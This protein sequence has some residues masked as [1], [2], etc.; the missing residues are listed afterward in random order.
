MLSIL[1]AIFYIP[2]YN[3][4]VAILHI[5][6]IDAGIAVI[7]L[8]C[9]VKLVLFPLSKKALRSQIQMKEIDTDLKKIK[10]KYKDDQQL[11][12]KKTMEL[13]KEKGINPFSSILVLLI[14][15]P[16]IISL[17]SIFRSG[18]V[19]I[20]DP[21]LLYSFVHIPAHVS[22]M[23]LGL[24][25]VLAKNPFLAGLTAITQFLQAYLQPIPVQVR[26]EGEKTTFQ[27]D[28]SRSMGVQVRYVFPIM[29][30]FISYSL[31]AVIGL[32]WTTSNLF[33]IG[34]ELF[35]REDRRRLKDLH[36]KV[37]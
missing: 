10:E 14:Q 2:L 30:F 15:L 31:P 22:T 12:A 9:L 17:Y 29:V 16:I 34:Q 35:L 13:Y 1:K 37:D 4:F 32:Y 5:P 36:Q 20:I 8:T 24:F 27:D 21:S 28:F 6:G 19:S 18:A 11:Q 3:L 25:D 26:K 7:L 23:F 33:T